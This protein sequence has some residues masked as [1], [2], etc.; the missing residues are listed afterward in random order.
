MKHESLEKFLA[1]ARLYLGLEEGQ[2]PFA[3]GGPE[4]FPTLSGST[5]AGQ[6]NL[7]ESG[8][9]PSRSPE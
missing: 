4:Q 3:E 1:D 8:D 7:S 6:W 5:Q 9:Q 2:R